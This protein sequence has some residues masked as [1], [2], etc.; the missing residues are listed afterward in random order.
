MKIH[1]LF[2]KYLTKEKRSENQFFSLMSIFYKAFFLISEGTNKVNLNKIR[3]SLKINLDSKEEKKLNEYFSMMVSSQEI[4]KEKDNPVVTL[5][6]KFYETYKYLQ[7]KF[8]KFPDASIEPYNKHEELKYRF[9]D[10]PI[11]KRDK[12]KSLIEGTP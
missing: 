3:D 9:L 12:D 7:D 5:T 10:H 6:E 2:N 4:V 11:W 8:F 1:Q